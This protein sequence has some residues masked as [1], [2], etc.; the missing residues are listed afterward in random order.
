MQRQQLFI[1]E[2]QRQ[3]SRWSSDWGKVLKLI[4]AITS[5][6]TS[7]I[8]SLKRLQPLVELVFQVDTSKIDT[9]HLEGATPMINGVSYVEA[10]PEEIAAAVHEFTSP[11][12]APAAKAAT[13]ISKKLYDVTVFNGSGI[14][15]LSTTSVNQLLAL[16]YNA[17]VG[18]DDPSFPG[19]T[20]VVYATKS[21]EQPAQEVAALFW[22]SRVELVD[23]APGVI[24][25]ISVFVASSFG[26]TLAVPQASQQQQPQQVLQKK[27]N[28][29]AASWKAL[30][31]QTP[32]HLQMPTAWPSGSVY[33]EFRHYSIPDTQRHNSRAAV[34][35]A[36]T[37]LGGYWSVQTMRW[38]D[39]PAI[40]NPNDVQVINGQR[41][42]LFYQSDHLHMVAWKKNGTLYWVLNTLDNQ[43]TNDVMLGLATSFKPVK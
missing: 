21:L 43:L 27:V 6:T 36:K 28:Y 15:G 41:Y 10:T 22:P 11:V 26:G 33:D 29:D 24:D 20:T 5:Q 12:Q 23:R 8:D 3:S 9:V 19:T 35:V 14:P 17:Q 38:T 37:P 30:A 32:L 31:Q 34:V 2:L 13:G 42:M 18:P 1:K 7:D 40:Q 16:G 39:P 4:K 25:G